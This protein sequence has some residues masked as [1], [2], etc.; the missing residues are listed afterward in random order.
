MVDNGMETSVS[1]IYAVGDGAGL[2]Q[3]IT[4][5]AATGLVSAWSL[6]RRF[7]KNELNFPLYRFATLTTRSFS[8]EQTK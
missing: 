2:S 7:N 1:G 4:H 6:L 8:E 3:G 5:A